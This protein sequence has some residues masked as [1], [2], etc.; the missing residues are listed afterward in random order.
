MSW[1]DEEIYVVVINYEE[2][3]SI[4]LANKEIPLGWKKEGFK[5]TKSECL[6]HIEKVWTEM[7][8]LSLRNMMEEMKNKGN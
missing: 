4:W 3:Y 6:D 5:G 8:P 1:D 7:R 2:Q